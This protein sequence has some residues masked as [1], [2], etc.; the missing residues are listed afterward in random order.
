MKKLL[1]FLICLL[2]C[3]FPLG[4][5]SEPNFTRLTIDDFEAVGD[6]TVKVAL[7]A[8]EL[9]IGV[10]LKEPPKTESFIIGFNSVGGGYVTIDKSKIKANSY[11]TF[12]YF[13][14][15]SCTPSIMGVYLLRVKGEVEKESSTYGKFILK[16]Y[17]ADGKFIAGKYSEQGTI[18]NRHKGNWLTMEVYF[19]SAPSNDVTFSCVWINN[20]ISAS[21]YLT[22]VR[23]SEQPLMQQEK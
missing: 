12:T 10:G 13:Y 3:V 18:D 19:E 23:I 8:E 11:L 20:G 22:N 9:P 16:H 6:A 17:D 14:E 2:L 21:F 15:R 5:S 1:I 4:C 7:D